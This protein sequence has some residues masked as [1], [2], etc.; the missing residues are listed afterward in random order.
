MSTQPWTFEEAVEACKDASDLQEAAEDALVTAYREAAQAEETYRVALAKQIVSEHKGGT[1]WTVAPDL[2]RGTE[3]V[4]ALKF[5]RD[6]TDGMREAAQQACWRRVAD[7]KDAQRFADWSQ[8]RELA[9]GY[10]QVVEP[11]FET[12]GARG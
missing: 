12:V 9:E 5:K 10:G 1:A 7:R 3:D 2:A 6:L 4:A 11:A 8:R